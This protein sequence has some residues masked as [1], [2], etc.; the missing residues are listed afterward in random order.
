[1]DVPESE[2]SDGCDTEWDV[3]ARRTSGDRAVG[4][5]ARMLQKRPDISKKLCIS[6]LRWILRRNR[7]L[8]SPDG[9]RR[10]VN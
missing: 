8:I 7:M 4:L 1:M 2:W 5:M 3:N 10:L 6:H 9:A